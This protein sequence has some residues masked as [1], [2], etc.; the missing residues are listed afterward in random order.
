MKAT[1]WNVRG[2]NKISKAIG[3]SKAYV[4]EVLNGKKNNKGRVAKRIVAAY[5]ALDKAEQDFMR[6]LR[7]AK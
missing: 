1:T 6:Q 3:C 2:V 5:N 7:Q 4:S